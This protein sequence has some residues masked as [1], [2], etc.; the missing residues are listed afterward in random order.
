MCGIA[1]LWDRSIPPARALSLLD[2]M[3][4]RL[5]RRGPDDR[6]RQHDPETGLGLVHARLSIVDLSPLG[7][8][9]MVSADGRYRIVYNGEIYNFQD[10]RQELEGLGHGFRGRSDTEVLLAAVSRWSLDGALQRFNG[11]YAFALWDA[12]E[13]RLHLVRDPV[14]EKPLYFGRVGGA[15]AFAS[16]LGALRCLPG[17]DNAV[18]RS[19]LTLL[20][21]HGYIPAP[22][23]IFQDIRKLPAGHRV[24]LDLS[25]VTGDVGR[26]VPKPYRTVSA[27]VRDALAEP[28]EA[29][30]DEPME[31]LV[32]RLDHTLT[33]AVRRRLVADVPIG[34][35]L[36]GGI[37]S[38]LVVALMQKLGD[39]PVR[40]FTIG[41]ANRDFDEAPFARAVAA[42]LG[43]EHTELEITSGQARD[44]I[45][46]LPTLYDEPFADPS[47]IPTFLVSKLAREQVGVVLSG[48]GGDELF[49]GYS[50]Y[51]EHERLWRVCS[52]LPYP[53]R[54]ALGGGLRRLAPVGALNKLRRLGELLPAGDAEDFYLRLV[55][56]SEEDAVLGA[57][58]VPAPWSLA[59]DPP[60][61][62]ELRRRLMALDLVS[63]L[64]EGVL[65]KLDRASMA[66]GLE[67]RLP[68]LDLDVVRL[69][70]RLPPRLVESDGRSKLM[71]RRVLERYVPRS[72]VERP[73]QGFAIP[74]GSWLRGPLRSWAEDLLAPSR[75]AEQGFFDPSIVQARL[76]EHMDGRRDRRFW[77]WTILMF[78][79]WL[80][81]RAWKNL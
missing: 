68:L 23:S 58:P 64:S 62:P 74:V 46:A 40:T 10:L 60:S 43:T 63:Y 45:P 51:A 25:T 55:S 28:L 77:L 41:F 69:A 47:Q 54:R 8:Q 7:R 33:E 9:P 5:R 20:L 31:A 16:E 32:D 61:P 52:T 24:S 34:A 49:G 75:L 37:D 26:L 3:A 76:R 78:Q 36:S 42:H 17:F 71:L 72:L 27:L 1:G 67:G 44:L 50:R 53:L 57:G 38:S 66:V 79:Q 15:F 14:G 39:R 11:M 35:F 81:G 6:G 29:S 13:R 4:L 22:L 56:Q 12:E 18:D 21:R 30:G 59:D 48:D 70:W 80:D 19:A 73:K 65:V 2:D